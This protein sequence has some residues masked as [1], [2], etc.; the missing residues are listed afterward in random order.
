MKNARG[1]TLIELIMVIVILGILAAVALPKFAD[2]QGDARGASIQGAHG[3]INS[4]MAIVHSKSIIDGD[5]DTA[6]STITLEGT[7]IDVVYG[8]PAR[9]GIASAAGLSSDDYTVDTATGVISIQLNCNV[10]YTNAA[11]GVAATAVLNTA[12]C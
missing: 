11:S 2:L 7:S 8:Y 4:A 10:T 5:E 1:F 6:T 3:A 12:G 9:T